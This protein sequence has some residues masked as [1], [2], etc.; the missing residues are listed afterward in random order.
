MPRNVSTARIH[1]IADLTVKTINAHCATLAQCVP[2]AERE[3]MRSLINQ[4]IQTALDEDRTDRDWKD[5][6]RTR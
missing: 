3:S 1:E 6:M 2:V 5:G 4:A